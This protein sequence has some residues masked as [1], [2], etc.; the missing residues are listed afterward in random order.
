MAGLKTNTRTLYPVELLMLC[1][2]DDNRGKAQR[3]RPYTEAELENDMLPHPHAESLESLTQAL[4]IR[5]ERTRMGQEIRGSVGVREEGRIMAGRDFDR[6][7]QTL[8]EKITDLKGR[9][10]NRRKKEDEVSAEDFEA[11]VAFWEALIKRL[12][13]FRA[14]M[15]GAYQ[16]GLEE[17]RGVETEPETQSPPLAEPPRIEF[18]P[19]PEPAPAI[20]AGAPPNHRPSRRKAAQ[21]T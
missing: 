19:A 9:A 13:P 3:G 16:R 21:G 8:R 5:P 18:T 2:V 7:I 4:M 10:K 14:R 6:V 1:V 12:E 11:Q 17:E 20:A 15:I